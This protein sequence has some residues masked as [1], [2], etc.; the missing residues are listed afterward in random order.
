VADAAIAAQVHQALDVHGH[1]AAQVALD[2]ELRDLGAQRR[3]FGVGQILDL[4][5]VLDPGRIANAARTAVAD[6]EN[7]GQT[8]DDMLVHRNVDAGDTRHLF[9]PCS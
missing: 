8:D 6:A 5:A 4:D 3:H 1:F 2:R 7:V 9:S